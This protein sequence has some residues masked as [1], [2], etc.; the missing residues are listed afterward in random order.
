MPL[1]GLIMYAYCDY[2]ASTISKCLKEN[3]H[4]SMLHKISKMQWDL[5]ENG[6]FISTK[7]TITVV[8]RYDKKYRITVEE[9]PTTSSV[10]YMDVWLNG[11]SAQDEYQKPHCNVKFTFDEHTKKLTDVEI[12]EKER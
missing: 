9:E 2:I 1:R 7:K 10:R 8:D 4:D 11:N 6:S 12:V 5:D 3:D